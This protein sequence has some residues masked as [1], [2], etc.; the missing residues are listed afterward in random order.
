MRK[1]LTIIVLI[2]IVLAIST[3]LYQRDKIIKLK[4]EK[5]L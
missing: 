2:L 5:E 3:L 4:A 1:K